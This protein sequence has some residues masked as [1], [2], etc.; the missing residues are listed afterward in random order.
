MLLVF[1]DSLHFVSIPHFSG[2]GGHLYD[3]EIKVGRM[4]CNIKK[5]AENLTNFPL[6][7]SWKWLLPS[8]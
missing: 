8:Y 5:D 6:S 2:G 1:I 7:A 4:I 3:N